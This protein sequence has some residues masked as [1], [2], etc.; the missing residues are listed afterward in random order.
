MLCAS[1][2]SRGTRHKR[3]GASSAEV[4]LN[5][6]VIRR[7]DSMHN[8][9]HREPKR[10]CVRIIASDSHNEP[11]FCLMPQC[12][13]CRAASKAALL[14]CALTF[15]FKCSASGFT[16]GFVSCSAGCVASPSDM[17]MYVSLKFSS[18]YLAARVSPVLRC[19]HRRT[20]S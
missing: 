2:L 16:S 4:S 12:Q 17:V 14:T 11:K 10:Q 7:M 6:N 3:S 5:C 13:Q 20:W 9:L 15:R 8:R 18:A 1:S 19:A